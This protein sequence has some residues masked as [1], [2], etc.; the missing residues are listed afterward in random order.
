MKDTFLVT[1]ATGFIGSNLVRELVRQKKRVS[2]I[3]RNKKLNWRL[4]DIAKNIDI[5]ECDIQDVRL[6]EIVGKIKPDY[7]FHLARYGNLPHEDD[8]DKMIDVNLKGTINLINAAKQNP[9]KLFI[10]TSSCIEYGI[11]ENDMKEE[12]LLK[13][14]NN[15]GVIASAA[16]LYCQKEAIRNDSL[17]IIFRLFTPYGYFE[18]I[19]RLI[20]GVALNAL[21]GKPIKVSS[22][23]YVRDFIFI[24]D[25]V[26]A[27][28]HATKIK[29]HPGEIYNIGSSKQH[30]VGEMVQMILKITQSKSI[31]RWGAVK[32]QKRYIEPKKW[33]A[34]M[35]KT[36]KILHWE[37]K[38]TIDVGLSKTIQWIAQ[39]KNLY[40]Q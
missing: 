33:Q 21:N 30:S 17:I 34:D 26:D 35:S 31:V 23:M 12:D 4:H 7:I 29:H 3:V 28:I 38:N 5:H 2:I 11:K 40:N 10:N 1:G 25:V 36:K 19:N 8:I 6:H 14:I 18:G 39:H 37:S 20:P 15:F 13:P 27:Y 16:T 32:E 9:F 24:E 22:P